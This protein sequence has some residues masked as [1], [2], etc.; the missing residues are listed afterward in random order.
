MTVLPTNAM[1]CRNVNYDKQA[2][3]GVIAS[4]QLA[5]PNAQ[6]QQQAPGSGDRNSE[7]AL[8]L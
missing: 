5:A 8:H 7:S 6:Q 3:A 2:K 4:N 1:A